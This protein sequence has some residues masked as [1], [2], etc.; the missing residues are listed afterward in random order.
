MS[1]AII[2]A[3]LAGACAT[4]PKPRELTALEDLAATPDAKAA[5]QRAPKLSD[6]ADKALQSSRAAWESGELEDSRRD[7]LMGTIKLKTAIALVQQDAARAR[8]EQARAALAKSEEEYAKAAKD[9]Q[10]TNDQIG[11]L[12][13]LSAERTRAAADKQR[14]STQLAEEQQRTAAEKA[15]SDAELAQKTADTVDARTFAQS[16]YAAAADLLA[17]AQAELRASNWS[18]AH[19]SADLA[20]QKADV[21]VAVA[22]PAFE[23]AE[24]GKTKRA[25]DEALGRDAAAIAGLTVRLER[26]GDVT[27][28][29]LPLYDLFKKKK[30]TIEPGH[31]GALGQVA[32]L[33][34][35][36]PG[37]PVQVV[38]HTDNKGKPDALLALSVARA[39]A[40]FDALASRGVEAKRFTVSGRAGDEPVA[41]NRS[42]SGRAQNNRVE[43]ILLY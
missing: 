29:V 16:D 32:A 36:Y 20:K 15:V 39:Q 13:K 9:L 21:A 38:G 12:E 8:A 25:Q 11:L 35:K 3:L 1:R 37:Y 10:V 18:A 7:A 14:L 30:T 24:A 34:V 2:I 28:L 42:S 26:R 27:R 17:R 40:V 5:K 19:T 22:R 43:V 31:D 6:S 4:P 33:L 41:D 23:Q